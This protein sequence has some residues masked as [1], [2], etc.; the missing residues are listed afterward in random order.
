MI[1]RFNNDNIWEI[2]QH[3]DAG[4]RYAVALKRRGKYPDAERIDERTL[5]AAHA[6]SYLDWK[7]M[8]TNPKLTSK[9]LDDD[10]FP[11]VY[12][13]TFVLDYPIVEKVYRGKYV[14]HKDIDD[15]NVL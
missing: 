3:N 2:E 4:G 14:F 15:N 1:I 12:Y 7:D 13:V 11:L 10:D 6:F 9:R 8:F 5:D